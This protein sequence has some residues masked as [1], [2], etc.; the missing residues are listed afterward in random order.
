MRG[1]DSSM[2]VLLEAMPFIQELWKKTVVIKYGGSAM[3]STHHQEQFARD[4]VMLWYVGI[5]PVVVHGGGPQVSEMMSRLG[6]NARFVHG[7]RVTDEE[8]MEVV[9]M[10]LA[11]K[12]NKDLV[13]LI[14][15]MG[16][17]AV[18]MSGEDGRLLTC[19]R[20]K[21]LHVD[22]EPVDLGL[23]GEIVSV[24][25]KALRLL[26]GGVIPVVASIGADT[27]GQCY[28]VNADTAAGAIAAA[29]EAERIVLLTDVPGVRA[30]HED[31]SEVIAACSAAEAADLVA[32]GSASGGMIPKLSAVC[33]ALE[34]GVKQAHIIDGRE[35]HALLRAVLTEHGCGTTVK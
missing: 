22:G 24:D 32:S 30:S 11:G 6:L 27:D 17:T 4:V 5:E 33:T 18:G 10:V 34:G 15:K 9:R 1:D 2:E 23:V 25:P 28:N 13:R 12:L 8:T 29:V 3:S 7:H 31:E 35:E 26:R 16:G 14:H 21:H 19:R 20:M